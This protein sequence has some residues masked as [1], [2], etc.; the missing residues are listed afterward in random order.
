MR[1][2]NSAAVLSCG[3][4]TI[5]ARAG[6]KHDSNDRVY[7]RAEPASGNARSDETLRSHRFLLSISERLV[8]TSSRRLA[9]ERPAWA[10][11]VAEVAAG[12]AAVV[13]REA[14]AAEVLPRAAEAAV[15]AQ[16]CAAVVVAA[17]PGLVAGA[18]PGRAVAAAQRES[19]AEVAAPAGSPAAVV[20]AAARRAR[21][22]A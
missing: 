1:R 15:V 7:W 10:A 13:R 22:E 20:G 6:Y 17:Q 11:A 16:P 9:A 8:G 21:S 19:G 4:A 14:V 5:A 12:A 3:L 2:C 18:A